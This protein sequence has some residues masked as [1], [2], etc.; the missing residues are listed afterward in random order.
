MYSDSDLLPLSALQHI[1][2][3]ERQCALIHVEHVW[4]ENQFTAEGRALHERAHSRIVEKRRGKK[5][6]RGAA[7]RSLTLGVSGVADVIETDESGVP[8][9][10]EYKRGRPKA[11]NMDE[12]QLCA[13]AMCLE[14]MLGVRIER[15]A[16]FYGKTK[17]RKV[18][19]FDEELRSQTRDAAD[20]LHRL[21]ENRETPLPVYGDKCA[22]CSLA[23]TCMPRLVSGKKNV[24]SYMKRMIAKLLQDE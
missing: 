17:R 9:P 1:V 16:I 22:R 3:C 15:G 23:E 5:T 21:I 11:R 13:Q 19:L 14:E 18:V 4:S 7:I 10:V 24:G 12:V 2:F 6:E 8:F 20:R